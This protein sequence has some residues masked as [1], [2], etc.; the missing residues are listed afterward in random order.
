MQLVK[1]HGGVDG[2]GKDP[3]SVAFETCPGY[4]S[5]GVIGHQFI[6][7]PVIHNIHHIALWKALYGGH[8]G[9]IGPETGIAKFESIIP[10]AVRNKVKDSLGASADNLLYG[11]G[12]LPYLEGFAWLILFWAAL[13]RSAAL[14]SQ[15]CRSLLDGGRFL[16]GSRL[17]DVG[18]CLLGSRSCLL[19]IRRSFMCVFQEVV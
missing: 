10:P 1:G 9:H 5:L 6:I 16:Y 18:G 19:R 11:E 8:K 13:D 7:L 15:R 12:M 2:Y 4:A 17:L 14:R 3:F